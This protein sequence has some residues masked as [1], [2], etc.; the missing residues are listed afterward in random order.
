MHR[1]RLLLAALVLQARLKEGRV[2]RLD[3]EATT[4][5]V[6]APPGD[7]QIQL[8]F[9]DV[10]LVN[11]IRLMSELTGKNF[12]LDGNVRGKVTLMAPQPVSVEE[13]Y[14][15][16]VSMLQVQ[17]FTV[18]PQGAVIK[19]IP[20]AVTDKPVPTSQDDAG[21]P[22]PAGGR[23]PSRPASSAWSLPRRTPFA[24]CCRR[25]SPRTAGCCDTRRPTPWSSPIRPPTS[26]D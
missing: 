8:N 17:G 18:V 19:V 1:F 14:R 3:D 4:D 2:A 22:P 21:A 13:A 9:R 7:N 24:A 16:F 15:V 23:A 11:V 12:L 6:Q 20:A 25:W 10:E 26:R 5:C